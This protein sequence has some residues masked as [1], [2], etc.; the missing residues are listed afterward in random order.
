[1]LIDHHD[2]AR[3]E[4]AVVGELVGAMTAPV[5]RGDPRAADLELAHRFV[6]PGDQLAVVAA[7][8]YLDEGRGHALPAAVLVLLVLALV[9][10]VGIKPA[11]RPHRRG[12]VHPPRLDDRQPMTV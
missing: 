7:R 2:I 10:Q 12:L 8:A 5:S 9:V 4:P 3:L 6:V 11:D 1:M